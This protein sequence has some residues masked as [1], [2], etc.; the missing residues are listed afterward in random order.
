[1]PKKGGKSENFDPRDPNRPAPVGGYKGGGGPPPPA[2]G[3]PKAG[4]P[5]SMPKGGAPPPPPIP[6]GGKARMQGT[7]AL[8]EEQVKTLK[9]LHPKYCDFNTSGLM[10]DVKPNTELK[11]DIYLQ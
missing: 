3:E 10:Y 6:A 4:G 8:T 5:E 11:F 9:T 7:E 1:M 2:V